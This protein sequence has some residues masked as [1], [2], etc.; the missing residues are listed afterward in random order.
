MYGP[1][2][3]ENMAEK[4][5]EIF[6]CIIQVGDAHDDRSTTVWSYFGSL[7]SQLWHLSALSLPTG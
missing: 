6:Y 7:L 2:Q 4:V 3:R 1:S 5:H